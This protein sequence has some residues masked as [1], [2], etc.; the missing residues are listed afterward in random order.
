MEDEA[1][2]RSRA[3]QAL[4]AARAAEAIWVE[5]DSLV[6]LGQLSEW[7]G[8]TEEAVGLFTRALQ[9]ARSATVLGV[10]LRAAFQLARVQLETGDLVAASRTAHEG[11][12]RAEDAGVGLAPYGY[13]LQYVHY[14]AH[15]QAGEWVHA[16][17]LADGFVTRVTSAAEARLAAMALFL[18]VARDLPAGAA[19]PTCAAPFFAPD[20]FTEYIGRGLLAEHALWHGDGETAV[21]Q[22]EATIGASEAWGPGYRPGVIRPAAVGLCA[23]ADQAWQAR[24][25]GDAERAS[26]AAEKASR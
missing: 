26:A 3:E 11:Q 6:T 19:P 5:A 14:L 8:R 20:H 1:P 22:A 4:A 24:A 16:Q 25:A 13:D 17:E 7:A 23:V 2:A 10:E 9:Q 21:A 18:D 15:Y 12:R